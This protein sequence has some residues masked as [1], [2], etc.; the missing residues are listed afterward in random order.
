MSH[1]K[2]FRCA[3]VSKLDFPANF[4]YAVNI[5]KYYVFD[6][7]KIKILFPIGN[8]KVAH[9]RHIGFSHETLNTIF[10]VQ[11]SPFIHYSAKTFQIP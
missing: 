11:G 8:I 6:A 10:R 2:K 4:V 5:L 9:G 1:R 7:V 3:F